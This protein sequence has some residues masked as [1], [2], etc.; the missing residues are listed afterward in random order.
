M[1][2]ALTQ[3]E[4]DAL[5]SGQAMPEP[6]PEVSMI[7]PIE[8]DTANRYSNMVSQAGKDV[9]SALLGH[10][11]SLELVDFSEATA[12]KIASTV[13]NNVVVG[14]VI[15]K[16]MLQGKSV[17]IAPV[18]AALAVAS[19]MTGGGAEGEFG[20][21]EESAYSEAL[22]NVFS[23]VNI[24]ITNQTESDVSL[25]PV[26]IN[27]N[28]SRVK[29]LLPASSEKQILLEYQLTSGDVSAPIYQVVPRNL[30]NSLAGLF[31]GTAVPQEE[32]PRDFGSSAKA[33]QIMA[34]PPQFG[35]GMGSGLPMQQAFSAGPPVDLGNLELILD[36]NIEVKVELGR[37]RRK[38]K[39]VLELG[40][41]SVVELERL[42][43]EPVDV[44]V[45][46]KLFAKGEVVVIDENFGVRITDILSIQERIEALK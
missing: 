14:D 3:A 22:Q 46:D 16:G 8:E 30:L 42:A 39:D 45:N 40:P 26:D 38:I 1:A 17:L 27:T 28:P 31:S 10:P 6:A 29:D 11:S 24:Q 32:E 7:T 4:I 13:G 2:E 20:D 23:N 35:G 37:T 12:D 41:G 43:G 21:L 5:L 34:S 18:E 36:I 25:E 15:Y 44:L 33:P 9:F 19:Q